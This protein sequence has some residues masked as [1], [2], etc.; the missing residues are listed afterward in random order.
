LA[1]SGASAAGAVAAASSL[2]S[3]MPRKCRRVRGLAVQYRTELTDSEAAA[4]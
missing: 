4:D 2:C 1:A 3:R